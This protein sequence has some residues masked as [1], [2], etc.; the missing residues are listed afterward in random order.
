[1]QLRKIKH[2]THYFAHNKVSLIKGGKEYFNLLHQLINDAKYSIHLQTYIFDEDETGRAVAEALICAAQRKVNVFILLD[3]YASQKLSLS[4][5]DSLT[6]AGV[7]FRWFEPLLKSKN[8]YFGRRLH[9][10]VVVVDS[11]HSLV[12]GLNI[13]NRYNDM[14]DQ[15]AWLDWAIYAQGEVA[16][17]LEMICK[18]RMKF[19]LYRIKNEPTPELIKIIQKCLVRV[20][21]NDWVQRRRQ[22]SRSYLEML[23][24]ASSHLIIMSPYF[25]PGNELR[26]QMA[27]AAR[28]GVKI[29][30]ILT[31]VSDVPVAKWAERYVYRWLLRNDIEIHE[32]QKNVLHGKMATYDN[33]W[34][35]V[36]SYNV[37]NLSAY[38]SIE[39]NLDVD[40]MD[41]A[42]SANQ[43]LEQ[44]IKND[45]VQIT[46][47]DYKKRN[48]VFRKMIHWLS[49]ESLRLL[50]FLT[51]FYFKQRE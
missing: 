26:K 51:T 32:Y 39:L 37:N 16:P 43:Q 18:R 4:F 47:E 20:R 6:K 30:V 28:R 27:R 29:K 21:V 31:G 15:V 46:E 22:I 48:G 19:H 14:P 36:G 12:S 41:F 2:P 34:T 5:I 49:Y 11:H 24:Q 35:T 33:Q 17:V 8:F 42:K 40:N 7:R 1:M 25:L 44:I 50:L 23:R 38:A 9:H 3:G 45:C 10:K 13:S